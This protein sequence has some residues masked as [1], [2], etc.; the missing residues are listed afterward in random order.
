MIPLTHTCTCMNIYT[1]FPNSVPPAGFNSFTHCSV[2]CACSMCWLSNLALH[3]TALVLLIKVLWSL[4]LIKKTRAYCEKFYYFK[5]PRGKEW[6]TLTYRHFSQ[7]ER[8]VWKWKLTTKALWD[9]TPR[10]LVINYRYFGIVC[11]SR[12]CRSPRSVCLR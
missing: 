12:P 9:I 6:I 10:R 8:T 3:P 1:L 2:S 5:I 7:D 4:L 11:F